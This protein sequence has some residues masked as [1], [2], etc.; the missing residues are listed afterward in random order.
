MI[1]QQSDK[2]T[3]PVYTSRLAEE[4]SDQKNLSAMVVL[5]G[6]EWSMLQSTL[7][8]VILSTNEIIEKGR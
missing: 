6:N 4:P 3:D 2:A 5:R 7:S 1:E 8:E